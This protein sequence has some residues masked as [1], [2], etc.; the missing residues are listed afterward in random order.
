MSY[1]LSGLVAG[2]FD[3]AQEQ[4]RMVPVSDPLIKATC[5]RRQLA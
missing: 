3:S 2:T 1:H 5:A 4:A